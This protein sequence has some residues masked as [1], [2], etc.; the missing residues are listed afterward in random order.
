MD[1]NSVSA[2]TANPNDNTGVD[3][4]PIWWIGAGIS[5]VILAVSFLYQPETLPSVEICPFKRTTGLPGPGCGFTRAF[6][7]LSHGQFW[8][9]FRFHPFV[10]VVYPLVVTLGLVP[11][12][13]QWYPV[14]HVLE[15]KYLQYA[16]ALGGLSLLLFGLAR[17][18]WALQTGQVLPM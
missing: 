5:Y 1:S 10:Y 8:L 2:S 18:F 13:K 11:F 15:S 12:L 3:Y 7:S 6:T 14:G 4:S 17:T 9:A 16:I